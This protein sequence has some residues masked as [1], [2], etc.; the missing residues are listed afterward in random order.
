MLACLSRKF[1]DEGLPPSGGGAIVNRSALVV[2]KFRAM[3]VAPA[4][5]LPATSS[6]IGKNLPS[7]ARMSGRRIII[8]AASGFRLKTPLKSVEIHLR[9]TGSLAYGRLVPH[10]GLPVSSHAFTI[11]AFGRNR[12]LAS[13]RI[14]FTGQARGA[15]GCS[16]AMPVA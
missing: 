11:L 4:N 3:N 16:A 6:F 12:S 15:R 10:S 8:L 13:R 9:P 14:L 5:E 2:P 7:G 1:G